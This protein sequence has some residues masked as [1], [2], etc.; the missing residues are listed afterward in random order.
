MFALTAETNVDIPPPNGASTEKSALP[1]ASTEKS[2]IQ[3]VSPEETPLLPPPAVRVSQVLSELGAHMGSITKKRTS[4]R[5]S[6]T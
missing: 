2:A 3:G 4:S 1:G 5:T 6:N